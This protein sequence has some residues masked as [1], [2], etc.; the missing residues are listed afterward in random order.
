MKTR[1][2]KAIRRVL[3]EAGEHERF[4]DLSDAERLTWMLGRAYQLGQSETSSNSKR[5]KRE[6][7]PWSRRVPTSR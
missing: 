3:K 4:F 2:K 6:T 1:H 5:A 7:R